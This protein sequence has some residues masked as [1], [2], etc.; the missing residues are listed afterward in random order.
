MALNQISRNIGKL[1]VENTALLLCDIQERF[2]TSLQYFDEMC[3]VAKRLV[4]AAKLMDIPIVA[5]EHYPKGLGK[6]VSELDTENIKVFDKTLFSMATPGVKEHLKEV[7]PH[8]K[9]VVLFGN[10]THICLQQTAL[11]F[12]E[13]D[14]DVHVTADCTASRSM[15]DRMI[16]F[17]RIRQS[18]G[19][20]TTSESVLFSLL[21][22]AK[23]AKFREVQKLVLQPAP[24]QGLVTRY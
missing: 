8:L 3:V 7:N 2:R 19:F 14:F 10:E 13:Q 4:T 5:T 18:G 11:D 6:I 16:A 12:L 22:D 24:E 17:E 20:I 15:T 21:K 9:A 23:N 1:S